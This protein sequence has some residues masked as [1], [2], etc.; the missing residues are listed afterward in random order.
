MKQPETPLVTLLPA[1]LTRLTALT[2][3]TKGAI[4]IIAQEGSTLY[5]D[6]GKTR[7]WINASGDKIENPGQ[8]QLTC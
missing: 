3:F 1:Q 2:A 8:E 4:G 5:I 6:N 7:F